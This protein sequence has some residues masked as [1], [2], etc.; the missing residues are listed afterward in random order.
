MA[1]LRGPRGWRKRVKRALLNAIAIGRVC[2]PREKAIS[3]TAFG[4]GA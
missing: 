1:S 4:A 3:A 2:D